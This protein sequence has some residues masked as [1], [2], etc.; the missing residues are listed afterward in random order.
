MIV[1]HAVPGAGLLTFAYAT[2]PESN[3]LELQSWR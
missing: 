2:D 1:S 3:I